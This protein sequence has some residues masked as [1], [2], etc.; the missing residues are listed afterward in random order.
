LLLPLVAPPKREAGP[1]PQRPEDDARL[2]L[3]GC[4]DAALLLPLRTEE[5][6]SHGRAG[7]DS[8][9]APRPHRAAGGGRVGGPL[10]QEGCGVMMAASPGA[11]AEVA[12][13]AGVA[14]ETLPSAGALPPEEEVE[15]RAEPQW[16]GGAQWEAAWAWSELPLT[17][18]PP[19]PAPDAALVEALL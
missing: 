9:E 11:R 4:V 18:K 15:A 13:P 17:V 6:L 14:L 8:R 12:L 19:G 7:E 10:P 16:D 2:P 5:T 1:P 3:S